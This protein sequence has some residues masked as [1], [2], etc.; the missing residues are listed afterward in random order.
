MA[1]GDGRHYVVSA[2]AAIHIQARFSHPVVGKLFPPAFF[3]A[4]TAPTAHNS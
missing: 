1:V 4:V 2:V 3:I